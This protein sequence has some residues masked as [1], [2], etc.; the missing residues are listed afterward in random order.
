MTADE[1]FTPLMEWFYAGQRVK[2]TDKAAT[3]GFTGYGTVKKVA[4]KNYQVVQDSNPDGIVNV[5]IAAAKHWIEKAG[6]D[7]PPAPVKPVVPRPAFGAVVRVDTAKVRKTPAGLYLV[8]GWARDGEF[9]KLLPLGVPNPNETYWT[10]PNSALTTVNVRV[11][12][13]S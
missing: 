2:F 12:E 4:T 6:D 10:V 9:S 5:P 3:K 13:I 8:F 11:E 7:A 1:G